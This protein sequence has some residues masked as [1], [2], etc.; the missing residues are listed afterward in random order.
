MY[1][2]IVL[3][4]GSGGIATARRAA[5][6]GARVLV[7]EAGKLGGTCV[8]LGCV[9]KKIM[10]T[11]SVVREI[12]SKSSFYGTSRAVD[13]GSFD[14]A[15]VKTE[16]DSYIQRL[17]KIYEDNLRKDKIDIVQGIGRLGQREG[18]VVVDDQKF[19]G[20]NILIAIGSQPVLATNV[21]GQQFG[22]TSD[23]FF[24]LSQQPQ[25]VAIVGSGYIAVELAGIFASLG[26]KVSIW[27]RQDRIMTHFD[28]DIAVRLQDEMESGYGI[29]IHKM[30]CVLEIV[31]DT[32]TGLLS[33]KYSDCDDQKV[34]GSAIKSSNNHDCL[35]WAIGR[36][37]KD[38][39]GYARFGL[40]TDQFGHLQVNK[41]QECSKPGYFAVGDVTGQLM[42]TPVAIAAGRALADRLFGGKT[43]AHL[44][45][46]LVPSVVF[47]HPPIGTIGLTEDQA[48]NQYG[49][50][51]VRVYRKEFTNMFYALMPADK[52]PEPT[53]YK[54]VTLGLEEKIV[55]LHIIGLSSDEILQ[56]A[57]IA[58]KMGAT[59]ADFDATVAIHPTAS[60]ELVYFR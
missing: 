27:C 30:S 48:V 13:S 58:I 28:K 32:M 35:I 12:A 57:A 2:L 33:V 44:D 45:Y 3:G 1:D 8:N 22:I 19:I 60:E 43:E 25:N 34:D 42:L 7:V 29:V 4:A 5:S 41:Y 50:G 14:W 31:K 38:T 55:G 47:S 18:E 51:Q 53:L 9:P 23:G 40:K 21:P 54:L 39:I 49:R 20:K 36:T 26:S 17:N 59:K 24:A 52:R 37:A 6:Y 11:A 15:A 16:R 46:S 56:G 10:W